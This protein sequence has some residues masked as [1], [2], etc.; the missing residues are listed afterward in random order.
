MDGESFNRS[1]CR[2]TH[3][4]L[5]ALLQT[6]PLDRAIEGGVLIDVEGYATGAVLCIAFAALCCLLLCIVVLRR[7]RAPTSGHV[8]LVT[9]KHGRGGHEKVRTL[10]FELRELPVEV[11]PEFAEGRPGAVTP[12][13][14]VRWEEDQ[15]I[16]EDLH[17]LRRG[18]RQVV[19]NLNIGSPH[20]KAPVAVELLYFRFFSMRSPE[21]TFL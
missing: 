13:I 4:S 2:T 10:S 9:K 15:S 11:D 19:M 5:F 12:K 3:T 20:R 18:R 14:H 16:L 6:L 7:V 1:W 21:A 17:H 8:R